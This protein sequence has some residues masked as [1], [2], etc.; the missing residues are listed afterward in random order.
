[1]RASDDV[2]DEYENVRRAK[3]DNQKEEDVGHKS[4]QTK[5]KLGKPSQYAAAV[6][7]LSKSTA[8]SPRHG[9]RS[10]SRSTSTRAYH[11]RKH[12]QTHD[13]KYEKI[14]ENKEI[15]ET[16]ETDSNKNNAEKMAGGDISKPKTRRAG[17]KK[18]VDSGD[19][20]SS[21][22]VLKFPPP[23]NPLQA[24]FMSAAA[25][26]TSG[27]AAPAS[28]PGPN[29]MSYH[30]QTSMIPKTAAPLPNHQ[31]QQ[32][33]QQL[34]Y[35]RIQKSASANI[36][37]A[38]QFELTML[39]QQICEE[40]S[41]FIIKRFFYFYQHEE[42]HANFNFWV[43]LLDELHIPEDSRKHPYE[44]KK[45][46][47]N[48]RIKRIIRDDPS[49]MDLLLKTRSSLIGM[50]DRVMTLWVTILSFGHVYV[51]DGADPYSAFLKEIG[52]EQ[53][54]PGLHDDDEDDARS[55]SS[56]S[57]SRRSP[58]QQQQQQQRRQKSILGENAEDDIS[59]L[60]LPCFV[61]FQK[62]CTALDQEVAGRMRNWLMIQHSK[63]DGMPYIPDV[64]LFRQFVNESFRYI[65]YKQIQCDIEMKAPLKMIEK[66]MMQHQEHQ[67]HYGAIVGTLLD[68]R[69]AIIQKAILGYQRQVKSI[70]AA[71]LL[72]FRQQAQDKRLSYQEKQS[73]K[74][75]HQSLQQSFERMYRVLTELTHASVSNHR[76]NE[77]IQHTLVSLLEKFQK[78]RE[79][80]G[81][82]K[83]TKDGKEA[84]ES[85]EA[86]DKQDKQDKPNYR[87]VISHQQATPSAK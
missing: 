2:T 15:K 29:Q 11:Y 49:I 30:L 39:E 83:D 23:Q 50:I 37:P 82:E 35:E 33:A 56:S 74:E 28:Y 62:L 76:H 65:L 54:D 34:R 52:Q 80:K 51:V 17:R 55:S 61:H 72:R 13:K 22:S 21:S 40:I 42:I 1:M 70:N 67:Q 53:E 20:G 68:H 85:K 64:Q 4:K 18:K 25:A 12:E 3:Y 7:N 71:R 60:E 57:S 63:D 36:L 38:L 9:S 59:F 43:M 75:T 16:K 77:K 6:M 45:H 5:R 31:Q 24:M 27:L 87:A 14:K 69:P 8:S 19:S 46:D 78:Q 10:R 81:A 86:K 79:A 41:P 84:K 48:I 47:D 58:S 66:A 44:G 73:Y 32:P 26:S